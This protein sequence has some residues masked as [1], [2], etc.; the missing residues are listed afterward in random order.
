MQSIAAILGMLLLSG[1]V[2]HVPMALPSRTLAGKA[3]VVPFDLPSKPAVLIVGFSRSSKSQTTAWSRRIAGDARLKGTVSVFQVAML[4]DVPSFL[5]GF[6]TQGIRKSV[7]AALQGRFLVV[8]EN[9]NAWKK[10]MAYAAPDSAY[11]AVL[12]AGHDVVWR[13]SGAPKAAALDA[14]RA[15]VSAAIHQ[16]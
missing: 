14:L 10:L 16:R 5:R 4:E 9:T 2:A 6:V 15:A 12:D 8:T 11:L 3:F 13:T 1:A 7:P